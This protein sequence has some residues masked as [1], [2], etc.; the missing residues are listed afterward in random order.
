MQAVHVHHPVHP[1]GHLLP[2]T[3]SRPSPGHEELSLSADARGPAPG[4]AA[5]TDEA[6]SPLRQ[7]RV[8]SRLALHHSVRGLR[9]TVG[10]TL[11]GGLAGAVAT[12]T[13]TALTTGAISS[14]GL[15][16]RQAQIAIGF[17]TAACGL[18][19]GLLIPYAVSRAWAWGKLRLEQARQPG[20][21]AS[22]RLEQLIEGALRQAPLTREGLETVCGDLRTLYF[23][24]RGDLSPAQFAQAL[25]RLG[26]A[27]TAPAPCW[28]PWVGPHQRL[29]ALVERL[30]TDCGRGLVSF[31]HLQQA[32]LTLAGALP[33]ARLPRDETRRIV[34]LLLQALDAQGE[35][36]GREAR[37]ARNQLLA[38]L[39]GL[40]AFQGL[41]E[42]LSQA[43]AEASGRAGRPTQPRPLLKAGG[44]PKV[45][46]LPQAP[47][48]ACGAG[49]DLVAIQVHEVATQP[50][51]VTGR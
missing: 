44:L 20:T 1:P 38:Q 15:A 33:T 43:S 36:P 39:R 4:Q 47:A 3:G 10:F 21:A 2:A 50:G 37:R 49:A 13:S 22:V 41:G 24:A 11:G 31:E 25:A 14:D 6:A 40:P 29:A 46:D 23:E 51:R 48:G 27:A 42:T 30:H 12:G 18:V 19:G 8:A 7:V 5:A 28:Q 16:D 32:L 17:T 9:W 34:V 45:R 26:P 35:R